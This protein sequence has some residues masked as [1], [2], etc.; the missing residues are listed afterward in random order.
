MVAQIVRYR[1]F[2]FYSRVI[3]YF[4]VGLRYRSE[5]IDS[6]PLLIDYR[7]K[8]PLIDFFHGRTPALFVYIFP[9]TR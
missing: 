9:R 6:I 3:K 7:L 2:T 5:L 8:I 1:S 4:R